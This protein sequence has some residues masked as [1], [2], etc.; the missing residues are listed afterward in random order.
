MVTLIIARYHDMFHDIVGSVWI[1]QDNVQLCE[2]QIESYED[3]MTL[4]C[5]QDHILTENIWFVLEIYR[6]S[7]KSALGPSLGWQNHDKLN[8]EHR[9]IESR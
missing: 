6:A 3:M 5:C 7:P 9:V 8:S 2:T 1:Q 4:T